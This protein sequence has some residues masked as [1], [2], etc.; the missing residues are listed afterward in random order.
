[1]KLSP[2]AHKAVRAI[3]DYGGLLAFLIGYF[4][5]RDIVQATWWLVGGSGIALAVG[6]IF[7][8]R[9]APFPLIAGG[10]ALVF[11]GLTLIFHDARFVKMKP[12]VMNAAFA[13][14]LLGGLALKKNPLKALLGSSIN[15][16]DDGWR[17]LTFRYG[18]FFAAVAGL[19]EA[20]WRTQPDDIWVVFRFPGLMILT[21]LFSFS[22]VPLMM[23]YA[24][25]SEPPPP[26][27]E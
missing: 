9:L 3:V 23:K 17:K 16:P 18:L 1:M 24:K 5:S 10:A 8:R 19:N 6:L 26:H 15:M 7:E 22:Q 14:A 12:S 4:V 21:V 13:I 27:V 25:T 11:G 20:V 2:N